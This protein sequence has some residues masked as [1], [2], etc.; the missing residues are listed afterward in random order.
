M[1][2]RIPW[3]DGDSAKTKNSPCGSPAQS[4]PASR[5]LKRVKAERDTD[6]GAIEGVASSPMSKP[7]PK[8]SK[9]PTSK[10]TA[11]LDK[12]QL[13]DDEE[14]GTR[15]NSQPP[16]P[17]KENFMTDGLDKDDKYRMVEDE[18]LSTAGQFTAHLHKA[19]YQRLQDETKSSNATKIR[20]ISRPV[21]GHA[22]ELVRTK[23][24]RI[25]R[26]Q[27]QKSA[28]R[29]K[30]ES[31]DDDD[32]DDFRNTTLFG[33]MESPRKKPPMLDH[34]TRTSTARTLFGVQKAPQ[35]EGSRAQ[36]DRPRPTVGKPYASTFRDME[37]DEDD[38]DDL[39]AAPC[40]RNG[41]DS[42]SS[43]ISQICPVNQKDRSHR[44]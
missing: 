40:T 13:T 5:P 21:V 32:N 12:H 26:L 15:S 36:V 11:R 30:S 23:H 27:R 25:N 20:N 7:K 18:F 4:G 31:D 3:R 10:R 39:E 29:K 22:T 24:D 19:E 35:R 17:I 8:P 43:S 14:E 44:T 28:T 33:L 1:T 38:D 42:Q 6:Q 9:L 41:H 34:F 2:R 37:N 16:E